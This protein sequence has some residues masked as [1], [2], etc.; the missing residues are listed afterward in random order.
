MLLKNTLTFSI[1]FLVLGI[2]SSAQAQRSFEDLAVRYDTNLGELIIAFEDSKP[3]VFQYGGELAHQLEK[4][5]QAQRDMAI[6]GAANKFG[7]DPKE[8][9]EMILVT[10]VT[11]KPGITV[12]GRTFPATIIADRFG[13]KPMHRSLL[14]PVSQA[15][16]I[17]EPAVSR[18][19]L[20]PK[21]K[22]IFSAKITPWE[23]TQTQQYKDEMAKQKSDQQTAAIIMAPLLME[24]LRSSSGEACS[25]VVHLAN[26]KAVPGGCN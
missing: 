26:G 1:I 19:G 25:D 17:D 6:S 15:A 9:F 24:Y 23:I 14:Y 8:T 12:R 11:I 10:P 3:I 18:L 4:V 5:P 20:P 16:L 22:K 13:A 2:S 7:F 21:Q